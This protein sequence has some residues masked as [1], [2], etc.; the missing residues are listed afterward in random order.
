M[1]TIL[2][3]IDTGGPGGAETVYLNL[4]S[5]LDTRSFKPV[6]VVSREGWLAQSLRGRGIEPLIVAAKGSFN[7][8]YLRNLLRIVKE[9]HVDLIVAHLYGSAVYGSLVGLLSRTPVISILHGQSD[10]ANDGRLAGVKRMLVSAGSKRVVFVSDRLRQ[11]LERSLKVPDARSVVIANGVDP[12]RFSTTRDESVR[13][14]LGIAE[15]EVLVGAIGNIR[16]PKSYDVFLRAAAFLRSR[17]DRYRFVIVGE[18]SGSLYE[19]LLDLRKKLQLETAVSF[20]GLRSDV[21]T[22]LRGFDV[23]VSSSTTEGFSIACVEAM[24]SGVPV[25]ATRSGGPEEIVEDGVSGLLVPTQQPDLLGE[26]IQKV[27][28]DRALAARLRE[29]ALARVHGRFTLPVM[30]REYERV[31]S[32]VLDRT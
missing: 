6:C 20:L 17:S 22:L 1:K 23:Y 11:D 24:A 14:E 25:V 30:L 27:A 28:E 29:R 2:H 7:V 15:H 4:A 18:P 5:G 3:L 16:R 9:K 21:P 26:A 31:F 8:R 10:I 12:S 13:R 19:E 32:Q